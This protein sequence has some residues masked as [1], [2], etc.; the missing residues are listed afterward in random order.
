VPMEFTAIDVETANFDMASICQIGIARYRGGELLEEWSSL[1][2]P[3]D[4]FDA[5]NIHIHG[6]TE[7]DVVGAPTLPD[8]L[9][10]LRRLMVGKLCVCHT[11]FDRV[12]LSRAMA[13]YDQPELECSWLD[14][15]R[16]VR[17]A[18]K[19]FSHKGYG[20][21]R[22]CGEFGYEFKHHDALEDAKAAAFLLNKAIEVTGIPLGDWPTRVTKPLLMGGASY[23]EQIKQEG[24]PEGDLYGEQICFTGELQM[25]RREAAVLA[26]HIGCA[27]STGVNKKTTLLVVGDQDLTKLARHEKSSKHLKAEKLIEKGQSIRVLKESDFLALITTS[28]DA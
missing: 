26:A 10:E 3:E 8:L 1:V 25:V 17:R 16:V 11:H 28:P 14:S 13:R 7:A 9:S 18:W 6:I 27:V 12:S 24:N 4:Y 21:K 5:F 22:A 23:S 2:D 20:I 15:A 19:Q